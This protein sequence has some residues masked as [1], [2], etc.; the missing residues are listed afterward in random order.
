[1]GQGFKVCCAPI[2]LSAGRH[3]LPCCKSILFGYS[4]ASASPQVYADDL[5]LLGTSW[6]RDTTL[7][8]GLQVLPISSLFNLAL[9]NA[10]CRTNTGAGASPAPNGFKDLLPAGLA[11]NG[12]FT[13]VGTTPNGEERSFDNHSHHR[14]DTPALRCGCYFFVVRVGSGQQVL[15]MGIWGRSEVYVLLVVSSDQQARPVGAAV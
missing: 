7:T 13:A 10:S 11:L 5:L 14:V 12:S 2:I 4:N 3:T 8:W 1:M 9:H 6:W 15:P